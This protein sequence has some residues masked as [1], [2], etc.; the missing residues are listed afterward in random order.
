MGNEMKP[1]MMFVIGSC[2]YCRQAIGWMDALKA[3]NEKYTEVEIEII[4]E[5]RQ[6]DIA[7]R[8]DYYLVPTY[9]VGGVKVHEGIATKEIVRSV[10]E[11]AL[12]S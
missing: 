1:V 4:D 9:Y 2:P 7:R 6:R 12:T 5:N 11:K 10:F 3:E 8:F